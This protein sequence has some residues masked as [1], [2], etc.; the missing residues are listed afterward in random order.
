[1]KDIFVSN[2]ITKHI[3]VESMTCLSIFQRYGFDM[4]TKFQIIPDRILKIHYEE[5]NFLGSQC[6]RKI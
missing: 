5:I 3:T 1:M 4:N 6:E 2:Y